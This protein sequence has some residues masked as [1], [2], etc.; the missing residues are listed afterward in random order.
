MSDHDAEFIELVRQMR[1]A[2][3]RY[4][5]VRRE[6]GDHI[7]ALEASRRLERQVDKALAESERGQGAL[8]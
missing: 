5:A 1:A 4:F 6:G 2:Q 7:E 8:L 3:K